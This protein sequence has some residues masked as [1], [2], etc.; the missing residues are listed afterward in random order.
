MTAAKRTKRG[1]ESSSVSKSRYRFSNPTFLYPQTF[2]YWEQYVTEEELKKNKN[3]K[4]IK[5]CLC[6]ARVYFHPTLQSIRVSVL[7][8]WEEKKSSQAQLGSFFFW[9]SSAVDPPMLWRCDVDDGLIFLKLWKQRFPQ[10]I[11]G[12][13]KTIEKHAKKRIV[14]YEHS[15]RKLKIWRGWTRL[16]GHRLTLQGNCLLLC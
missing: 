15:W 5:V 7:L 1:V 8:Q 6:L 16:F 9:C 4:R 10:S 14:K 13:K 3:K 2:S 12:E 11:C